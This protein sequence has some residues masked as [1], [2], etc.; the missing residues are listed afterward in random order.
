MGGKNLGEALHSRFYAPI[1]GGAVVKSLQ[2][3]Q[4]MQVGSMGRE[5]PL[6]KEMATHS[7]ILAWKISWDSGVGSMGFQSW[8]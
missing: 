7:G 5:D 4:R 2:E 1:P 3:N 6:A 8:M